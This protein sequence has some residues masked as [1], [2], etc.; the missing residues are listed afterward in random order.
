MKILKAEG[1]DKCIG[2]YSCM[3]ACAGVVYGNFSPRKS[4]I[5]IRSAGGLHSKFLALICRGC[6]SPPCA[7]ACTADALAKRPGGG[8][9]FK[10]DLCTGCRNCAKACT[11]EAIFFDE[12]EGKPVVCIQ[13]GTC[14]RYCPH[15]V[16]TMEVRHD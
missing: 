9:N 11:A 8:V 2:C 4:A 3:L 5:Q 12:D 15:R 7:G 13:C 1:M 10:K 16:I 14:T 6:T